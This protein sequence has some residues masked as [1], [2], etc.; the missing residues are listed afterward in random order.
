MSLLFASKLATVQVPFIFKAITDDLNI[1]ADPTHYIPIT[2]LLGYG[3]ARITS[4]AFKELQNSIF[5][6]VAQRAIRL[7]SRDIFKHLFALELQFHLDRQTGSLQRIIDR[8]SK[9]INFV[10]TSL[11]FNVAP[12]ILE[13]ILVSSIFVI[14]VP[15]PVLIH[16]EHKQR[17]KVHPLIAMWLSI[18]SSDYF[19]HDC[20]YLFHYCH[21]NLANGNS[22]TNVKI[23]K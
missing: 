7:V 4:S 22:K 14:H 5:S 20:L 8:G 19:N 11:V 6:S 12:T 23:R 16:D 9:S 13:I 17:C 2:L 3:I 15:Y 1:V 21:Y 10:L 18:Q